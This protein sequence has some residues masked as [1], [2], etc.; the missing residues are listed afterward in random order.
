MVIRRSYPENFPNTWFVAGQNGEKDQNGL[1]QYVWVCPAFGVDWVQV[2]ERTDQI[3][4]G[5]GS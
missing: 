3:V 2:Y 5:M 1:P 4:E